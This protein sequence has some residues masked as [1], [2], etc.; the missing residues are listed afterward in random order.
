[1]DGI[2]VMYVE[3]IYLRRIIRV[4]RREFRGFWEI[5]TFKRVRRIRLYR[6]F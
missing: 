2:K 4:R 5:V 6:N 3:E 1:M